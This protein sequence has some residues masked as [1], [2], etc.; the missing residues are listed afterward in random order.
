MAHQQARAGSP[1]PVGDHHS[2]ASGHSGLQ[3]AARDAAG[4]G[5]LG[6]AE[7]SC[8]DSTGSGG[9]ATQ[10]APTPER[11]VEDLPQ[12]FRRSAGV[13]LRMREIPVTIIL[14][15]IREIL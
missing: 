2:T 1:R 9:I 10:G 13:V 4:G 11:R 8:G 7:A 6:P 12:V 14:L 5:E 3:I 15:F